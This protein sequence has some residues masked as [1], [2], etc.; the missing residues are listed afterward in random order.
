[1]RNFVLL[2][3]AT[4]ALPAQAVVSRNVLIEGKVVGFDSTSVRLQVAKTIVS[5]PRKRVLGSDS[6]IRE[7][8][9]VQAELPIQELKR[10]PRKARG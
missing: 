3:A 7:G 5:V 6:A 4:L 10:M 1:M 8:S 2:I 9:K